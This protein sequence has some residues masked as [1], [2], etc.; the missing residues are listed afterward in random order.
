MTDP[1]L[2]AD[3]EGIRASYPDAKLPPYEELTP[4]QRENHRRSLERFTA[5]MSLLGEAIRTGGPLP[6]LPTTDRNRA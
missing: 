4:E 2:R 6:K 5:D 3:Y 1:H